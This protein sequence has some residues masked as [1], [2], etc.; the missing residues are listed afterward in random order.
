MEAGV[1]AAGA[2]E[3]RLA[4]AIRERR[5]ATVAGALGEI[6]SLDD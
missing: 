2:R 5:L 6:G 3:R 4:D 1:K